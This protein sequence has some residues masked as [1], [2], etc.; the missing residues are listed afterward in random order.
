MEECQ[1]GTRCVAMPIYNVTDKIVAALSIFDVAENI[2]PKRIAEELL[3]AMNKAQQEIS[4]RM[5]SSI[6]PSYTLRP[7]HEI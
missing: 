2:N 1:I 4:M 7:D 3:P 5:G 6:E